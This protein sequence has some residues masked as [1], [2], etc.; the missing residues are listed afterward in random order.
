MD[1]LKIENN[2][3]RIMLEESIPK[4]LY[5]RLEQQLTDSI[6]SATSNSSRMRELHSE[7][8]QLLSRL[9]CAEIHEMEL[10][11]KIESLEDELTK[12]QQE[13]D[14]AGH[15]NK[16]THDRVIKVHNSEIAKLTDQVQL[17][18]ERLAAAEAENHRLESLLTN[19]Q[20]SSDIDNRKT[21]NQRKSILS[22]TRELR[23]AIE[24]LKVHIF[25]EKRVFQNIYRTNIDKILSFHQRTMRVIGHELECIMAETGCINTD[26]PIVKLGINESIVCIRECVI[27]LLRDIKQA[28]ETVSELYHELDIAGSKIVEKDRL[29]DGLVHRMMNSDK[30]RRGDDE[31]IAKLKQSIEIAE[32]KLNES[33][34]ANDETHRQ[35]HKLVLPTQVKYR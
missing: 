23:S 33:R 3:L 15:S 14:S 8:Q 2:Q 24:S 13:L 31:A 12:L 32:R 17:Y 22:Q 25:N 29:I 28:D 11:S 5:T 34:M 4:T 6:A 26:S 35:D 27:S 9:N 20:E 18:Q 10:E 16:A 30:I 19:I 7:N 1:D 21:L